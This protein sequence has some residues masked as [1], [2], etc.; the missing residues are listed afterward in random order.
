MP[1][2]IIGGL[3]VGGYF[4]LTSGTLDS[5]LK[6]AEGGAEAGAEEGGAE[7]EGEAEGGEAESGGGGGEAE[8]EDAAPSA[9]APPPPPSTS[10]S[11]SPTRAPSSG[12]K[13]CTIGRSCGYL[14]TY[15]KGCKCKTTQKAPLR[16]CGRTQFRATTGKCLSIP[17]CTGSQYTG[18]YN[19]TT[20]KCIRKP[21]CPNA[22]QSCG[23][24]RRWRISGTRCVCAASANF[25]GLAQSYRLTIA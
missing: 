23:F 15:V 14:K 16:A 9:G 5:L 22:G 17:H 7:A 13:K 11:K 25:A 1:L 24:R 20:G 21:T 10:T 4:L 12:K 19:K 8:A 18:K 3:A 6:P 2:L